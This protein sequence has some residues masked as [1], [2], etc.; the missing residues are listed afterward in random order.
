MEKANASSQSCTSL[1]GGSSQFPWTKKGGGL[2]GDKLMFDLD[3]DLE[4][5]DLAGPSLG[6]LRRFNC[7]SR[8]F[9]CQAGPRPTLERLMIPIL[10]MV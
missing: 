9:P 2:R 7:R 1:G 6:A 5:D 8:F 10:N 4:V 3:A